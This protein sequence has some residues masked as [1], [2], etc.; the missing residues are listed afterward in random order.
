MTQDCPSC[1]ALIGESNSGLQKQSTS[2]RR[3]VK[4]TD[5]VPWCEQ[6]ENCH[7]EGRQAACMNVI[8]FVS[9]SLRS[10]IGFSGRR[11]STETILKRW[12][13]WPPQSTEC[14]PVT[15]L[16]SRRSGNRQRSMW[17]GKEIATRFGVGAKDGAFY[18]NFATSGERNTLMQ[19]QLHK[20]DLQL[21]SGL[22]QRKL[23]G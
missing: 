9:S 8:L 7:A 3:C 14:Y 6:V 10:P 18:S 12:S 20:A 19:P 1:A 13:L 22:D 4:R 17:S 2:A 15:L 11:P 23:W 5:L 21:R 16:F